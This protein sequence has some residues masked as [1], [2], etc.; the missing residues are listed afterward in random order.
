MT[1]A[2]QEKGQDEEE[3]V[4]CDEGAR[5]RVYTTGPQSLRR[6]LLPLDPATTE[7]FILYPIASSEE[8]PPIHPQSL[9]QSTSSLDS[10]G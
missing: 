5:D 4:L 8:V 1:Q 7:D 6:G 3:L 9:S 10:L 2:R